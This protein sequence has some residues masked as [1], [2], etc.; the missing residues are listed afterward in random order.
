MKIFT[1]LIALSLSIGLFTHHVHSDSREKLVFIDKYD[2][3][4]DFAV[5]VRERVLLDQANFDFLDKDKNQ[6]IDK[7]EYVTASYSLRFSQNH[8]EYNGQIKQSVIRFGSLDDDGDMKITYEEL[9]LSSDRIFRNFDLD[10]NDIVN[11]IDRTL[12]AENRNKKENTKNES[13]DDRDEKAMKRIARRISYAKN[14]L[15]MPST[16]NIDGF[17]VKY[18]KENKKSIS[19][20]EFSTQRREFFDHI[21]TDK[22]GWLSDE[23]YIGE[24]KTRLESRIELMKEQK[25]SEVPKQFSAYDVDK[26]NNISRQEFYDNHGALFSR[27]DT[28]KDGFVSL[29]DH[30]VN[31]TLSSN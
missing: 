16:H 3:N 4:G 31:K 10:E 13:A 6:K 20:S 14:L 29:D 23:E 2:S 27:L 21:D 18:G 25:S 24:Y 28:N 26:N 11:D 5:G 30:A 19:R 22:N 8:S 9:S 15:S 1:P 12:V 7:D 17:F